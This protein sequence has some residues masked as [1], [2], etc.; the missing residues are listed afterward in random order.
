MLDRRSRRRRDAAL[1]ARERDD[2]RV[3][4]RHGKR[5]ARRGRGAARD[6]AG[7]DARPDHRLDGPRRHLRGRGHDRSGGVC[8]RD[9]RSSSGRGATTRSRSRWSTPNRP[10]RGRGGR[11]CETRSTTCSARADALSAG[12]SD[13]GR[14]C[15]G[16]GGRRAGPCAR[17]RAGCP[18][19]RRAARR[20]QLAL[21]A[22]LGQRVQ[23]ARGLR[24][25]LADDHDAEARRM[26]CERRDD[27]RD[28][29]LAAGRIEHDDVGARLAHEPRDVLRI[30]RQRERERRRFRA[31]R[32]RRPRAR[33]RR[34][35]R[36]RRACRSAQQPSTVRLMLP[37]SY[38]ALCMPRR[39]D[40]G[41][42]EN[43][44]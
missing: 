12:R 17:A 1:R 5:I 7:D 21:P 19:R 15:A 14:R 40:A 36:P 20:A 41:P 27:L 18:R 34:C 28:R 42:W 44:C 11:R 37:R 13:R 22:P 24:E 25:V 4:A 30:G 43:A 16:R 10:T 23:V 6:A 26:L 39:T 33:D 8:D 35:R 32:G 9:R 2:R 29:R 3:G 31:R 38:R